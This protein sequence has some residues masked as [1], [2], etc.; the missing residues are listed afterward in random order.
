MVMSNQ[1]V[2]KASTTR[3]WPSLLEEL[4]RQIARPRR[5]ASA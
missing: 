1:M 2:D 5:P 4:A 3:S